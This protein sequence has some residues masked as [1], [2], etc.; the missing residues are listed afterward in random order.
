[1]ICKHIC[2]QYSEQSSSKNEFDHQEL[3][4][5]KQ[6]KYLLVIINCYNNCEYYLKKRAVKNWI[7]HT[8]NHTMK[9][10]YARFFIYMIRTLQT[11]NQWVK[12]IT[13]LGTFNAF[14]NRLRKE[15][16]LNWYILLIFDKSLMTKNIALPCSAS[17]R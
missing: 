17:G 1:M 10:M 11:K 7:L 4:Y 6:N 14:W 2:R 15:D 12:F 8:K 3:R 13:T 16:K 5:S 9:S